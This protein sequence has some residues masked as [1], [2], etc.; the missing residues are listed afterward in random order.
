MGLAPHIAVRDLL[1]R[2]LC[3]SPE[4]R[5]RPIGDVIALP[6]REFLEELASGNY[7]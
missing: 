4:P 1:K 3:V 6:Y 2:C 7:A 5:R